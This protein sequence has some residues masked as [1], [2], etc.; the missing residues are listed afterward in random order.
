M[1]QAPK[2][3]P[4]HQHPPPVLA[5]R[6]GQRRPSFFLRAE[7][8]NVL[9]REHCPEA[10]SPPRGP[11][12]LNSA[13][14]LRADVKGHRTSAPRASSRQ[15][16]RRTMAG[17]PQRPEHA[18]PLHSESIHLGCRQSTPF[19]QVG[20]ASFRAIAIGSCELQNDQKQNDHRRVAS[21]EIAIDRPLQQRKT[22]NFRRGLCPGGGENRE[23][24][25][26]QARSSRDAVSG[27]DLLHENDRDLDA[28]G[29]SE[30]AHVHPSWV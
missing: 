18:Q 25:A 9:R 14:G 16:G 28:H 11:P 7:R 26:P 20:S 10:Y 2:T 6:L 3:A 1:G 24:I 19:I 8:A 27:V 22:R 5:Q 30:C 12:G 13:R 23:G 29:R 21:G 15:H 17:I 4:G